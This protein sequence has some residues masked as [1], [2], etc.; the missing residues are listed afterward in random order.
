MLPHI[1]DLFV[2]GQ[3]EPDRAQGGLG[4]GLTLVRRL[5]DLHGGQVDVASD[6]PGRG[7]VFTVRL[8]LAAASQARATSLI[9]SPDRAGSVAGC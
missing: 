9:R 7:S 6:G 4:V 5:T 2:Q 1:F 3:R 8:P